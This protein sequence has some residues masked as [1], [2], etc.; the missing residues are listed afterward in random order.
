MSGPIGSVE[1]AQDSSSTSEWWESRR[2]LYNVRLAIA[3]WV[4]YAAYC[5]V[6]WTLL[7][8]VVPAMEID[9]TIFTMLFQG[10]GYLVAMGIANLCFLLG[11]LVENILNPQRPETLR[12]TLYGL[13][14]AFSVALPFLIPGYL[15]WWS[16][17]GKP[18]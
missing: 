12:Q 11:P 8:R 1:F 4:A 6:C 5:L 16:L 9:I 13:G 7:P 10:I 14:S 2:W 15:A 18:V 17:T 3:G